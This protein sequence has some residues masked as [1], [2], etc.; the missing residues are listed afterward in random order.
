MNTPLKAVVAALTLLSGGRAWA[1]PPDAAST[2]AP[3]PAPVA[4]TN[5][6]N[7]GTTPDGKTIVAPGTYG[8]FQTPTC[9]AG[10]TGCSAAPAGDPATM[11]SLLDIGKQQEAEAKKEQTAAVQ[12]DEDAMVKSGVY[13]SIDR[14]ADGKGAVIT[15]PNGMIAYSNYEKGFDTMPK[16]PEDLLKDPNAPAAVKA[17]AQKIVDAKNPDKMQMMA[18]DSAM[19]TAS[20]TGG[21]KPPSTKKSAGPST[22]AADPTTAADTGGDQTGANGSDTAPADPKQMGAWMADNGGLPGSTDGSTG[23]MTGASGGTGGA[24]GGRAAPAS[25]QAEVA[26]ATE[27]SMAAVGAGRIDTGFIDVV[28]LKKNMDNN[29][30]VHDLEH[31]AEALKGSG[32]AADDSVGNG[33]VS[34]GSK[35]LR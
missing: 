14:T 19:F 12:K 11:N 26:A 34:Q 2:D 31:S 33:K 21:S 20:S 16:S 10:S 27:K 13:S 29:T 25:E 4:T 1:V 17:A 18:A 7:Q 24:T 32:N 35:V 8:P 28:V 23:G 3:A 6:Y 15:L 9:E 5:N 30:G 22:P